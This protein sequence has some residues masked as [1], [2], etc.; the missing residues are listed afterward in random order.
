MSIMILDEQA[1]TK[2]EENFNDNTITPGHIIKE[3]NLARYLSADELNELYED[4]FPYLEEAKTGDVKEK[5][6]AFMKL[7]GV[8][9]VL[10]KFKKKDAKKGELYKALFKVGIK[11][12]K[13]LGVGAFQL[14]KIIWSLIK[15]YWK[16]LTGGL[17]KTHTSTQFMRGK[18]GKMTMQV[19]SK[20]TSSV[21][22]IMEA[23]SR[24]TG[25]FEQTTGTGF[26]GD[27][28]TGALMETFL[29]NSASKPKDE[30]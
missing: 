19:A 10:K 16:E 9:Q 13:T 2:I 7:P 30:E 3:F 18:G 21:Q 25:D 15:L 20:D 27:V 14:G 4:Y 22:S 11:S 17:E 23:V 29:R 6:K 24:K 28:T 1:L 5:V 26:G 12:L 8:P